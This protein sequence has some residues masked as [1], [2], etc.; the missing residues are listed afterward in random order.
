M[1]EQQ[2]KWIKPSEQLPEEYTYVLCWYEY[3]RYGDYNRM[4]KTYGIGFY[5]SAYNKWCGDVTGH[6]VN[7]IAWM[8]LPEPPR[9]RS[10]RNKGA[11][12]K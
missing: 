4:F 9:F 6:K 12:S 11:Q 2:Y 10:R 3:F 8:P 5:D 1:A 7:V